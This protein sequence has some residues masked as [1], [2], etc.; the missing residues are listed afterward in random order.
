MSLPSSIGKMLLKTL[1]I[2]FESSLNCSLIDFDSNMHVEDTKTAEAFNF[3]KLFRQYC[4][5]NS[6]PTNDITRQMDKFIEI[7]GNKC[8]ED[9]LIRAIIEVGR[10]LLYITD[11][12]VKYGE[13]GWLGVMDVQTQLII[14]ANF[15][16]GLN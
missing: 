15:I 12:I 9:I 10:R 3:F 8:R 13:S 14:E 5:Y 1:S 6:L 7:L 16:R 4:V 2:P 11:S